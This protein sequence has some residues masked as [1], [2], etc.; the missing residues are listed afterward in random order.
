MFEELLTGAD[1]KA[2][3]RGKFVISIAAGITVAQLQGWM[4]DSRISSF[5]SFPTC[6]LG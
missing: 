6:P 1:V 5:L 2:A 3:L 4:P